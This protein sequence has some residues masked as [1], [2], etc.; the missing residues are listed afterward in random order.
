MRN[1]K[2]IAFNTLLL[3]LLIPVLS[4]AELG[5]KSPE[6]AVKFLLNEIKQIV[7]GDEISEDQKAANKKHSDIALSILKVPEIS[8]KALGKYW[9]KQSLKQQDQFQKLLG[10]LFV[11]VAF[12]S[13]AKFFTDLD[14]IYGKSKRKKDM[15]VVPLTVIHDKEGEV[16]ID[17]WL[18]HYSNNWLVVDVI[19]DGI[20][21]RNNLRS[22]FYKILKKNDF[23]E[24][25][26]RMEK[27]LKGT[28]G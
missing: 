15:M 1:L 14:L 20:S 23:D 19:L 11:Y 27:K 21:M 16:D 3:F 26:R 9:A 17:F 8:Q 24:L 22:Q 7:E 10:N 28:Q 12:P 25:V 4:W 18:K 6:A 5:K 13:S 2:L